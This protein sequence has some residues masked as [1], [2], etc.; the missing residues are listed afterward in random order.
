M[1]LNSPAFS[2]SQ[3]TIDAIR[4]VEEQ[5][6]QDHFYPVYRQRARTDELLLI[7]HRLNGHEA[8]T[9][10]E[11]SRRHLELKDAE[12]EIL[13]TAT[14]YDGCRW[15]IRIHRNHFPSR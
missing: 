10:T 9:R 15:E 2:I 1:E 12:G 4:T 3:D 14:S 8:M 7:A 11:R 5:Q 6:S 13:L